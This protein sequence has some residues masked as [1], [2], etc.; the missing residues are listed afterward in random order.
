MALPYVMVPPFLLLGREGMEGQTMTRHRTNQEHVQAVREGKDYYSPKLAI[1]ETIDHLV[2]CA[3]IVKNHDVPLTAETRALDAIG[4]QVARELKNRA[5]M[6]HA[7][8]DR[9]TAIEGELE[10][11]LNERKLYQA[12]CTEY[13]KRFVE[14]EVRE[15]PKPVVLDDEVQKELEHEA[16]RWLS[17]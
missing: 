2:D 13:E 16:L 14:L 10:V 7:L 4:V 17:N 5:E 8:T 12:K 6:I 3:M 15:N 11:A 9:I 1:N